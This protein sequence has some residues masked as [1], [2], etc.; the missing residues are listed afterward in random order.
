MWEKNDPLSFSYARSV[1]YIGNSSTPFLRA[2]TSGFSVGV[3]PRLLIP[4][5]HLGLKCSIFN[6]MKLGTTGLYGFCAVGAF[7]WRAAELNLSKLML[8]LT[9]TDTFL[10]QGCRMGTTQSACNSQ[11]D[12]LWWDIPLWTP[13]ALQLGCF[14]RK[15]S[16]LHGILRARI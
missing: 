16:N 1:H 14:V 2:A 11:P 4:R 5:S 12:C 15:L 7:D 3:F 13:M 10:T 9:T 8:R 6:G